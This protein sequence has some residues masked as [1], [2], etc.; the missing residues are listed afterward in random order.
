[1]SNSLSVRLE[2]STNQSREPATTSPVASLDP[3]TGKFETSEFYEHKED[4][5]EG[6]L[7]GLHSST[8]LQQKRKLLDE[9]ESLKK[10][11]INEL[12]E[13]ARIQQYKNMCIQELSTTKEQVSREK[14]Y[15][16]KLQEDGDRFK[17]HF[18]TQQG[19]FARMD[20]LF[21]EE[22]SRPQSH[23]TTQALRDRYR[24]EARI[25][26]QEQTYR[27]TSSNVG[28]SGSGTSQKNTLS[29]NNS[30][31]DDSWPCKPKNLIQNEGD[32]VSDV[33]QKRD[34]VSKRRYPS[35]EPKSPQS[36]LKPEW[37][38]AQHSKSTDSENDPQI[39]EQKSK[40][41]HTS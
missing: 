24:Y 40:N 34:S 8:E 10:L 22:Q 27:D 17:Q 16:K 25:M 41:N 30:F 26:Q 15:L 21:G 33:E 2:P 38:K 13:L 18:A 3:R 31:K 9:I 7:D 4:V 20:K 23:P 1:M 36:L 12:E 6:K 29:N 37:Y 28:A 14:E 32:E 19:D 5:L 35:L 11:K 39:Q